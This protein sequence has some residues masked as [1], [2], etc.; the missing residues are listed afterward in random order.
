[1]FI[2][3]VVY[4]LIGSVRKRLDTPLCMKVYVVMYVTYNIPEKHATFVNALLSNF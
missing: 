4:F 3:V 2:T 1:V